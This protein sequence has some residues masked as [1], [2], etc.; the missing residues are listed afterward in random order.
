MDPLGHTG[1]VTGLLYLSLLG[2]LIKHLS[3]AF[4]V[5]VC[6]RAR[7]RACVCVGAPFFILP[8]CFLQ[9]SELTIFTQ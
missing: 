5:C 4:N 9:S 8:F 3:V 1:P 2:I 6:V 7:A